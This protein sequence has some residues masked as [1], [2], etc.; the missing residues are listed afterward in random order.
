[1]CISG[2][3]GAPGTTSSS[4]ADSRGRGRGSMKAERRCRRVGHARVPGTVGLIAEVDVRLRVRR[5]CRRWSASRCRRRGG[6]HAHRRESDGASP[7]RSCALLAPALVGDEQHAEIER[8]RQHHRNRHQQQDLAADAIGQDGAEPADSFAR[9]PP[10]RT[11]SRWSGWSAAVRDPCGSRSSLRRSRLIRMSTLRSDGAASR[12]CVRSMIWSRDRV[13]PGRSQNTSS[14]S[15]SAPV[16][17]TRAPVRVVEPPHGA[18][19]RPAGELVGPLRVGAV[20]TRVVAAAQHG[21][22]AGQ[23]LARVER[24]AEIVVGAHLEPDDALDLVGLRA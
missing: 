12:P 9:R 11:D 24:L 17:S 2:L 23:Q 13:R 1:M 19:E 10:A 5:R 6:D 16:S 20:G 8:L 22:D 18:I 7:T 4:T 3:P 15:N 21:A 14:T